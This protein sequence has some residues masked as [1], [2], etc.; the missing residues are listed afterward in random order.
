MAEG[1]VTNRIRRLRFDADEMTQQALAEA[2]AAD[3]GVAAANGPRPND[4]DDPDA[5]FHGAAA[6]QLRERE[7]LAATDARALAVHD[8]DLIAGS[9][10]QHLREGMEV[11][12]MAERNAP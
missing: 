7:R 3:P 5:D 1:T 9:A 12:R 10:V 11:R 8:G 6:D 4:P 2:I